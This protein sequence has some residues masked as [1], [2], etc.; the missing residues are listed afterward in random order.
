MEKILNYGVKEIVY[1]SCNP[2]TLAQNLATAMLFD[3]HVEVLKA[4]DNFPFTR[5][6]ECVIL[7]QRS[8]LKGEK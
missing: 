4:Y 2:K 5:H 8:G 6:V 3:Y 1:I 7:M